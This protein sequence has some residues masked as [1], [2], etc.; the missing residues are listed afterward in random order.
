MLTSVHVHFHVLSSV[1]HLLWHSS[2][3]AITLW[4]MGAF[5]SSPHLG[6]IFHCLWSLQLPPLPIGSVIAHAL[7]CGWG[8]L[9]LHLKPYQQS[10]S[11]RFDL[12]VLVNLGLCPGY[13][14]YGA[15][16][17]FMHFCSFSCCF[18]LQQ[19]FSMVW[20]ISL[21][22]W[23]C[24]PSYRVMRSFVVWFSFALLIATYLFFHISLI[25]PL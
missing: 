23:S 9:V 16:V 20:L 6:H 15:R 13:V 25:I 10:N 4:L 8:T 12:R 17:S 24:G 19:S 5:P 2:L 1:H 18:S 22:L 14:S 11:H 21:A 7:G 3:G